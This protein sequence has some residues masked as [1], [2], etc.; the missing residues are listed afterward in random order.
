MFLTVLVI[1]NRYRAE[2]LIIEKNELKN[3]VEI[4]H[5]KYTKSNTKL[6]SS[7]TERKIAKD[8]VIKIRGLKLPK[9]PLPKIVIK[10]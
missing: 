10:K 9:N 6:M 7:A 3:N 8:T 5:S 4:L 2:E 1:Y